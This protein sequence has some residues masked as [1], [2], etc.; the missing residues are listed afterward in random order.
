M[1]K[2]FWINQ[3]F[4]QASWPACVIGAAYGLLW[5]GLLVVGAF[6]A[7]QLRP[8]RIHDRDPLAVALFVGTGLV[9]ETIWVQSGLL[10]YA[11]PWPAPGTAPLWLLLLWLAL[12]LTVNHS[13]ASFRERWRL[14]ALLAVF[15][16]PMSYL[17]A[18]RF[19]AVDWLAPWWLVVLAVG[20]VWGLVVGLLFRTVDRVPSERLPGAGAVGSR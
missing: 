17:A 3:A 13:L 10:R 9:L 7:W 20:P 14:L 12:G 2:D 16:S 4:F 19:G 15:G 8:G 1:K 18:S 6:A 5:P 11:L